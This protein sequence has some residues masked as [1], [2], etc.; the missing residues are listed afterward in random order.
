MEEILPCFSHVLLMKDG[1]VYEK[2]L[3]SD[4]LTEE[5]LTRFFGRE[6][7]VQEQQNRTWI[8]IKS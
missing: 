7:S 3:A 5:T 6:V 8:A 4:L 1:E 2:G